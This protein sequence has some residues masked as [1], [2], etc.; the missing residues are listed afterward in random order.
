M[1]LT[2]NSVPLFAKIPKN[3]FSSTFSSKIVLKSL[4]LDESYCFGIKHPLAM[5]KLSGR[6]FLL[7]I[8]LSSLYRL[9][10]IS[11]FL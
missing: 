1:L 10:S 7:H 4:L 8:T 9:L 11:Q 6:W 2:R 5:R 3:T